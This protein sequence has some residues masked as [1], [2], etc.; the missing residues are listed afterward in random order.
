V[1]IEPVPEF[2]DT[3]SLCD[4]VGRTLVETLSFKA[5]VQAVAPGALPR[6]EMKARRF[7]RVK[8]ADVE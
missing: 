1:E 2:P 6:F 7:V 4:R 3:A 5:D 8:A